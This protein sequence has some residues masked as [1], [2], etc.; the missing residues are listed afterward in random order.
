[1][2]YIDPQKNAEVWARVRGGA[3]DIPQEQTL[4][5]LIARE[6]E[7]AATYLR[8]S[9]RTQ[10]K[11]SA[12]LYQLY[13]QEQAHTACLKGIYTLITGERPS[14]RIPAPAAESVSLT[15]RR[16]Y[17]REM[18]CLKEYEARASHPEYGPVFARLA[19]QEQ[20]HC[21]VILE[22]LGSLDEKG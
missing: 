5:A 10:G 7:D 21:R 20:E 4:A 11:L 19:R 2:E 22:L 14:L 15:L 12:A 1:M 9:R 16:C 8:L 3:P 18:Q 13:R 6:W 17:G